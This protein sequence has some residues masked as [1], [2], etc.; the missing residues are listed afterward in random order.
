VLAVGA[1]HLLTSRHVEEARTML[2]M[3]VGLAAVLA[4]L[5]LL[6][7]DQH[8]LNTLEQQPIKIAAMEGHWDGSK[9]HQPADRQRTGHPGGTIGW[10]REQASLRCHRS[11]SSK[12]LTMS[13]PCRTC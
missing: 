13:L 2:R 10:P 11:D 7:G 8:G 1:R 4:P 9:L 12:W 3:A 6:I 5:Q